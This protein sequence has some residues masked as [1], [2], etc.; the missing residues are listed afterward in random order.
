[1]RPA[2]PPPCSPSCDTDN[3]A[4]V[5]AKTL[6]STTAPSPNTTLGQ[7]LGCAPSYPVT[8]TSLITTSSGLF[9]DDGSATL[10]VPCPAFSQPACAVTAVNDT[11]AGVYNT[12]F[13]APAASGM[14]RNDS[15][16][17]APPALEVISVGA[18]TIGTGVVTSWAPDG[19]FA[20]RPAFG[21]FGTT[22]FPYTIIDRV[23]NK[24]ASAFVRITIP[25]PG[26]PLAS[27]DSATCTY[28]APCKPPNVLGN[29]RSL[30]GGV[31]SVASVVTQPVQG[32]VTFT[33]DGL[34]TYTPPP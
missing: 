22:L 34:F 15:S 3:N 8:S 6:V 12:T 1:V 14:L 31:L 5:T 18:P 32:S 21:W 29:D 23:I 9:L 19:S 17:G 27:E 4:T 28:G 33:P 30:A 20:F 26:G 25:S 16:G 11:Y 7:C 2:W 24:T 13:I 10:L